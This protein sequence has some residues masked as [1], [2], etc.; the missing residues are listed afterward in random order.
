MVI[1]VGWACGPVF[2]GFPGVRWVPGARWGRQSSPWFTVVAGVTGFA[3]FIGGRRESPASPG[4]PASP[5]L[6]ASH[7]WL[8]SRASL[9]SR[10]SLA[11][12]VGLAVTTSPHFISRPPAGPES[13]RVT[14]R[15]FARSVFHTL[16]ALDRWC[17]RRRVIAWDPPVHSPG[18]GRRTRIRAPAAAVRDGRTVPVPRCQ[19]QTLPA[20][21]LA[22]G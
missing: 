2:P 20:R 1:A 8:A 7:P 11:L 13:S 18:R 3:R 6:T 5:A 21:A 19:V 15:P 17:A 16:P 14:S 10:V 9:A 4:L 12:L 22:Y